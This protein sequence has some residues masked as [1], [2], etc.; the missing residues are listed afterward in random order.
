MRVLLIDGLNL[1]R[2]IYAGVPGEAG[3]PAHD[4][5]VLRAIT[6]S[7]ARAIEQAAPSHAA[8]VFDAPPP[9]WRHTLHD[10]Y[11]AS[12][13]PMPAALAAALPRIEA[14]FAEQGARPVRLAGHEADDVLAS[15]AVRVVRR[16]GEALVL[17]TDRALL[18]L[19]A[20]GVHVRNHF[21]NRDL[22]SA[23]VERRFGV[24]PAQLAD[25]LALVGDGGQGIPGVRSVGAKTAA[26]LLL[27]HGTLGAVLT[28]AAAM[29]G[30]TGKAL[31][32]GLQAALLSSRLAT[33][34]C[35]LEVGIN[36]RECRLAPRG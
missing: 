14:V 30:R 36:L 3:S 25:Y 19:L 4:A 9:T 22:D 5:D 1:V 10:G 29:P 27:E 17:S 7:L 31:R 26:A 8:G 12:R 2:R 16:G 15:M 33:L 20:E 18:A 11:K 32:E 35:D 13:P 34:R 23:E 28:A 24:R 21:E 6:Q